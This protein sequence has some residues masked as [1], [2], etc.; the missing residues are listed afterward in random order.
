MEGNNLAVYVDWRN[1]SYKINHWWQEPDAKDIML[2][3][4]WIDNVMI[5]VIVFNTLFYDIICN[6]LWQWWRDG[7]PYS[8]WVRGEH[9]HER[10][11][12]KLNVCWFSP[13]KVSRAYWYLMMWF[14]IVP[15]LWCW[16]LKWY[17][18][19]IIKSTIN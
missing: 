15:L 3:G 11:I 16:F 17:D 12:I 9:L 7:L 13:Y 4:L 18:I 6:I 10:L 5:I 14:P 2:K 1:F 8:H 19:G